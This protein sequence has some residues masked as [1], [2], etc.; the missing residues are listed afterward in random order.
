MTTIIDTLIHLP[1]PAIS[2][3]GVTVG[4]LAAV[5][6]GGLI[7]KPTFKAFQ[8]AQQEANDLAVA[9]EAQKREETT[10]REAQLRQ[11]ANDWKAS[12]FAEREAR[13]QASNQVTQFLEVMKMIERT[14]QKAIET[15]PP[16]Q[17]E[18]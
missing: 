18:Q 4:G 17:V 13:L 11:E 8:K 2:L 15:T 9:R 12:Y 3:T 10:A 7:P 6:N 5:Y 16:R 14:T 1:W